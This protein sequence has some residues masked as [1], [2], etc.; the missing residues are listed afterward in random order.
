MT[1][2]DIGF[3]PVALTAGVLSIL[4]PEF[5]FL[6]LPGLPLKLVLKPTLAPF[7][8]GNS[9]PGGEIGEVRVGQYVLEVQRAS[10][11]AGTLPFL[12]VAID[13]RAGL[14][15][16]FDNLTGQLQ[17]GIGSVA[18]A[19]IKVGILDNFINT[20]EPSLALA[21]P[22]LIA[23]VLPSLGDNLGA[24]PIPGFFGLAL[25]GVEVS[26]SGAFF[27]LFTKLVPAP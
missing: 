19:D 4:I 14:T 17:V 26:R 24:F 18:P 23:P 7:L 21:L 3:G 20:N 13:F 2:I 27:S 15:M 8:T 11:P 10:S 1:E 16:T 25:E 12:R 22:D 6:A 9:G 5:N